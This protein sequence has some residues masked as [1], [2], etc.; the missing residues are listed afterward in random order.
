MTKKLESATLNGGVLICLITKRNRGEPIK[1]SRS[2]NNLK[3]NPK[4]QNWNP[5]DTAPS[6]GHKRDKKP[7]EPGPGTGGQDP[8][9]EA[10]D[11]KTGT[12]TPIIY[13]LFLYLLFIYV[14]IIY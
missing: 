9:R 6:A 10:V 3:G 13:L 5:K 11:R 2:K 12:Q 7:R 4:L 14:F 1:A 8:G